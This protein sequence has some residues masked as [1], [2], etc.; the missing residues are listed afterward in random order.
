MDV[1]SSLY[2]ATT[3][4]LLQWFSVSPGRYGNGMALAPRQCCCLQTAFT[5]TSEVQLRKCLLSEYRKPKSATSVYSG[6]KMEPTQI[7]NTGKVQWPERLEM[8]DSQQKQSSQEPTDLTKGK[9][10]TVKQ[11]RD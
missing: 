1:G 11:R 4:A 5:K 9:T 3:A 8:E 10:N 6:T 7:K 2:M